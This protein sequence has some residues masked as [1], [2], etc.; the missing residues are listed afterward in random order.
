MQ[1]QQCCQD[2]IQKQN[3]RLHSRYHFEK[4]AQ[5]WHVVMW[6]EEKIP[7]VKEINHASEDVV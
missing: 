4:E 1:H 2:Q 5:T 7:S 6:P 3:P